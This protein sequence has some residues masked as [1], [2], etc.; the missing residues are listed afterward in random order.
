MHPR[1]QAELASL[2]ARIAR[3]R[4]C[5]FL[6]ETHSDYIVDRIRISVRKRV[7]RAEDVSIIFFEPQRNAVAIHNITLDKYG[8]IENAPP[9]YRTFFL[10]ETDRLLGFDNCSKSMCIIVDANKMGI[11][12]AV[13]VREEVAPIYDWLH[14][15]AGKIV[16]STGGKFAAEMGERT[17][18]KLFRHAQAGRAKLIPAQEFAADEEHLQT[19][20]FMRSDDPHVLALARFSRA[21]VL[22]KSDSALIQ[23]F[24]NKQ[25]ID[26]PRGRVYSRPTNAGLLTA[27]TCPT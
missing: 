22:Y 25:L 18:Q 1:G 26:K 3:K 16:Y 6:I 8:N 2:F 27:L 7:L 15:H 23:D 24:K 13:P 20:Q 19:N 10:R 11:F 12:L 4:D 5:R 9:T 21:R 17:K 14:R